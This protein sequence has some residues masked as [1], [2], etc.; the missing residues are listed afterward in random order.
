MC[1]IEQ[2]ADCGDI[3]TLGRALF[4]P[5]REDETWLS[6]CSVSLSSCGGLLAVGYKKRLC[7]LVGQWISSTDSNTFLISWSGTLPS[8]VTSLLSLSICPSQQ[9]SQ[10][11]PDW[12]CIVVGFSNGSVGFYTN[13]GHL[14]LLEKLED[15][16][17]LKISCNTGTYG[18][19]PDDIHIHF[20]SSV[21]VV[22]GSSLFQTLRNAKAQLAKVQ[23]GLRSEYCIDSRSIQIRK[24]I[25]SEQEQI[26]DAAVAGLDLT[27]AY[28]HYLAASNYGGYDTWYRSIPIVRTLILASGVD[29]YIGF[30]YAIEGGN[31]PK[32]QDVATA[33]AN[34]IKSALPGWLGG[35]TETAPTNTEPFIR[36][37]QLSL[38]NGIY[39]DQRQGTSVAVSQDRRLAAFSDNLGRVAVFDITKGYIIRLFKGC[40]DAQCAFVQIFDTDTRKPDQSIVKQFRRAIFLIIY[41]PKKGLI[42]IRLMQRGTRVAVFTATKNGKLLYNTCGL[43]G[44]EKN[45]THRKSNLP[46]FQ[47]VLIDPDGKL[48]EFNIPFYYCLGGEHLDRSKDLHIVKNIRDTVKKTTNFTEDVKTDLIEIATKLKTPEIQKLCLEILIKCNE[49]SSDII[50]TCLER[51]WDNFPSE[52][53]LSEQNKKF[54]NYFANLALITLFHRRISNENVSD[55]QNLIIKVYKELDCKE[56]S[57]CLTNIQD[58][59]DET[60]NFHLL[61]DDNCILERLLI[62][63]QDEDLK[64][65]QAKVTF[66]DNRTS[67]YK[68]FISCFELEQRN[69]Y[70]SLKKDISTE[71]L[72]NLSSDVFK[73]ILSLND[74]STLRNL[75][76]NC[77]ID[78]TEIVKLVITH[79]MNMSLEQITIDLIEKIISALYYLSSAIEE[80]INIDYNELSPWWENIRLMLVEL[81]CPLR[82]M[83]V[84]MA[85][86]AVVKIF[87]CK[88]SDKDDWESVTTENAEWGIL[89]GKLEDISILSIALMFKAEF[90]GRSLPRL[91]F[92]DININLKYIYTRGKGSVTELIA[93]WLCSMGTHPLAIEINEIMEKIDEN[94]NSDKSSN[95]SDVFTDEMYVGNHRELVDDNPQIFKWLSLLRRQFPLSTTANYIIANMSWEYALDWQKCMKNTVNLKAVV[96]CLTNLPDIH[97]RLGMFF[98]IWTTY[99]KHTFESCCRLVN[100]VGKLPKD[101]LCLQDLGF[102]SDTLVGFLEHCTDYLQEFYACSTKCLDEEA[103]TIRYEKIW[104]ES[105]PSLV[106]VA[107]K[108]RNVNS[109]IIKLNYQMSYT[110]YLQCLLKTKFTKPLDILYDVDYQNVLEALTGNV[111]QRDVTS[112]CSDKY[113]NQRMKFLAKLIRKA[114]DTITLSE[115]EEG[116]PKYYTKECSTSIRKMCTLADSWDVDSAFVWRTYLVMLYHL[117]YDRVALDIINFISQSDLILPQI[118]A[119]TIQR[120]KRHMQASKHY[121]QIF[122]TM[123]PQLYRRIDS[124]ELDTSVP[125]NPSLRTTIFILQQILNFIEGNSSVEAD[126][127][128]DMKLA[129]LLLESC[130][131]IERRKL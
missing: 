24:W 103:E 54:K 23:A 99:L 129:R 106:E 102:N 61:E 38:R 6:K 118:V 108:K 122:A 51:F 91:P 72:S 19:F 115:N 56:Q 40:R 86:K 74:Y 31:A 95:S 66:A 8:E 13:T 116:S 75:S 69:E 119:I 68:D 22:S 93:K 70:I 27:N 3:S 48:K 124:T 64:D 82:T 117:G 32:L 7:F 36:T 114:V 16:H 45:Y 49:L 83:I 43:V 107:Q 85:C 15:K 55:I 100:N 105:L 42:D 84:A 52:D 126:S 59:K 63:A 120:L 125:A 50:V 57:D 44:A 20:E 81:P 17:V 33:V 25:Y 26:N 65:H 78:S 11:G 96:E 128:P 76:Q 29:P 98:I 113:K 30:H 39:D 94:Q 1:S 12:F 123:P 104:N 46:E 97:L 28:E 131:Y 41:N 21:Y 9:S 89:I 77:K 111:V 73:S 2:I 87:E 5:E 110:I 34:K 101:H 90:K 62:L 60:P 88:S 112:K 4:I 14:L 92:E 53:T 10:S 127:L 18:I 130:E 121:G 109:E 47:C 58:G 79:V 35:S 37:E 67:T 71:K 80:A